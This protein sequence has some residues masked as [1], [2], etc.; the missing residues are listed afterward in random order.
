MLSPLSCQC[1]LIENYL[2]AVDVHVKALQ[3]VLPLNYCVVQTAD[4]VVLGLH[5][6]QS[7]H[8]VHPY[9]HEGPAFDQ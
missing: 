9:I 3:S 1:C 4:F 5:D 8:H 6:L 2:S 7:G